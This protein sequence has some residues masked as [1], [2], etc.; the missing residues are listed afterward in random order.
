[1][2]KWIELLKPGRWKD[3]SGKVVDIT[4]ATLARILDNYKTENPAHILVG[5]PDKPT[6][7]SFG[8]IES[9]KM[10]GDV[11]M[12]RPAN[13]VAEF[14][15]LVGKGAFPGVSAGLSADCS[16]LDHVAFLSAEKPAVE[17]LK[18]VLEFSAKPE[19]DIVSVD[20]SASFSGA[21]FSAASDWTRWRLKDIG[22]ILRN[23][24]NYLIEKEGQEKAD[25][26][27]HEYPLNELQADPPQDNQLQFSQ[28]PQGGQMDF[29]KLYTE[30][31]AAVDGLLAKFAKPGMTEFSAHVESVAADNERLK[32]E[33][34]ALQTK[35]AAFE[36]E[37]RTLEFSS[38]VETLIT[39]GRVLPD[40]KAAKVAMLETMHKATPVE[41]SGA[42]GAK[43]P[44]DQYKAEL[45]ALPVIAPK[46]GE[47]R[48]PEFSAN[49]NLDGNELAHAMETYIA[50]QK[51]KGVTVDIFEAKKH[52]LGR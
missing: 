19:S 14:A 4:K 43:S 37:K 3:R 44:L 40:Q 11:L 9:L 33:N 42:N 27:V 41:F 26:L 38:F 47:S 21:E 18:P 30:L 50:E 25:S 31:K 32:T 45:Q 7:P 22:T 1:M 13:V 23:I 35:C 48:G 36:S 10:A 2:P 24:K 51:A 49:G 29:E 28:T 6:V 20:I 34:A 8:I 16:R 17:G 39:Q 5:H 52:I 15:A 46:T 12:C